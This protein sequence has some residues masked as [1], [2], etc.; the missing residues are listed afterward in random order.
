M[1]KLMVSGIM[2]F[3]AITASAKVWRINNTPGVTADFISGTAALVSA[4]VVNDDTLYFEGSAT[5]YTNFTLSKRLVI[6]GTGYFLSG[7]NSNPGLQA[8]PNSVFFS[9]NTIILDS[10]GSGSVIMGLDNLQITPNG[11]AT[12]GT[13]TDNITITRCGNLQLTNAFGVT[14]NSKMTGWK[15]NKCYLTN[16]FFLPFVV[17]NWE[18]TNSIITG[19]ID[20][21]NTNNLNNLVRNNVFRGSIKIFSGYFSNNIIT[22]NTFTTTNV[23]VKNNISTGNNLPVGSGNVNNSTDAILFQGLT[24]NSTDGQWQLKPGGTNPAI[25]GGETISAITPDCGAYGTA[26]PYVLSGIPPIPTIYLLTVPSS[27]ASNAATMPITIST[28]S[29]N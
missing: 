10:T 18:I 26:D 28:K 14:P 13:A 1:K 6:I 3:C 8:N 17:Q 4:S 27:V 16:I 2:I 9:N 11:P 7:A 25:G 24:G 21:S 15:I 12:L 20:I 22:A 5:N 23:T 19:N 29:N